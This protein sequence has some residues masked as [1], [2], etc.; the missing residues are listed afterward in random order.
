MM[1]LPMFLRIFRFI[2]LGFLSVPALQFYPAA[3]NWLLILIQ[4]CFTLPFGEETCLYHTGPTGK[5]RNG[6][7]PFC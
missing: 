3:A 4:N 6:L 2:A 1:L 7:S 5:L